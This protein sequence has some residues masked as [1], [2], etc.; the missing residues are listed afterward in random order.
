VPKNA[1]GVIDATNVE[2]PTV[3]L[4]KATDSV[5]TDYYR[6]PQDAVPL[7]SANGISGA[8]GFFL[9]DTALGYGRCQGPTAHRPEQAVELVAEQNPELLPF[10]LNEIVDNLR[11]ER[12]VDYLEP[13]RKRWL[14]SS[15]VNRAY[16]SLRPLLPVAVRRHLQRIHLSGW[17]GVPF[18]AW[19]IDTTVDNLMQPAMRLALRQNQNRAIPFIWFWPDGYPAVHWLLMT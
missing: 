2:G 7:E 12:Y 6:C 14:H 18:P 8:R 19:P 16:Y 15:W 3:N 9:F 5:F 11:F 4:T 10:E 13:L 1:E 17:K